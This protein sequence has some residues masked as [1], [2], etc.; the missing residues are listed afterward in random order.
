MKITKTDM[1][2]L[3]GNDLFLKILSLVLAILCWIYIVFIT[4]PEIEVKITGIP[5]TL[6]NHQSIKNEGYIVSNEITA[7]V[8]IKVKGTRRMLAD[9]DRDSIIAYV[10]L[11]DCTDKKTYELPVN[12]KLPYED[13]SLVSSNV[14]KLPVTVDNYITKEIPIYSSYTGS[15]KDSHYSIHKTELYTETVTV[16]GPEP[17]VGTIDSASITIDLK[18]ASD[19]LSG[20]TRVKLLNSNKAEVTSNTL[21]IKNKDVS[22]KCTVYA[23][24]TV[25]VQPKL[26]DGE[27]YECTVSD[28]PTVTISGPASD[29][30]AIT[31]I[32][33]I[34]F[35]IEN[36]GI[37]MTYRTKI[38]IPQ[39]IMIKEN[40]DYVTIMVT[41]K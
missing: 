29:V 30:E 19:D 40:V 18:G 38:A 2:K 17:I 20:Y 39:D 7:T 24:K 14:I 34:P 36:V 41:K 11:I 32:P 8:D 10:D 1:K 21:D 15:L 27:E 28:H 33:T 23:E 9:L 5:I 35:T 13:I 25:P 37:S 12:I 31:S 3:M 4:N 26:Y 6:A 22:Y 16:S